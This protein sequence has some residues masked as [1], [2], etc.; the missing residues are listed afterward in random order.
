MVNEVVLDIAKHIQSRP[1]SHSNEII[2][3]DLNEPE[4]IPIMEMSDSDIAEDEVNE[5]NDGSSLGMYIK[6]YYEDSNVNR[7]LFG[8]FCIFRRRFIV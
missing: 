7:I 8:N 2:D 6:H 3:K 4:P 1:G 5:E